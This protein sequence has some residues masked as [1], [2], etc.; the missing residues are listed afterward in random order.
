MQVFI[1]QMAKLHLDFIDTIIHRVRDIVFIHCAAFVPDSSTNSHEKMK[2]DV[3][4][5]YMYFHE[6]SQP[7]PYD[8]SV[9]NIFSVNLF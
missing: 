8:D 6:L 7:L 9:V 5:R 3:I 2:T 1:K 4:V